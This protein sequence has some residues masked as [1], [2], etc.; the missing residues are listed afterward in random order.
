MIISEVAEFWTESTSI[1][2]DLLCS[3]SVWTARHISEQFSQGDTNL[4]QIEDFSQPISS[5]VKIHAIHHLKDVGNY[6]ITTRQNCYNA[7]P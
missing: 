2:S 4:V 3:F 7:L 5:T 1:I 6:I